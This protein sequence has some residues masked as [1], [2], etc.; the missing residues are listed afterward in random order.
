MLRKGKNESIQNYSKQY[1]ET[2]NKIEKRL[3]ELVV[4]NYKLDL[5]PRERLWENLKLNPPTDLQ[6]LMSWVE[7]FARLEDDVRQAE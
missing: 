3:E 4:A 5:T 6:D 2:Y 1:L 7:K